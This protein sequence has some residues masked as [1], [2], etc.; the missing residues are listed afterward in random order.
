MLLNVSTI[1][2]IVEFLDFHYLLSKTQ[3]RPNSEM[4]FRLCLKIL[5][6]VIASTCVKPTPAAERTRQLLHLP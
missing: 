6:P 2:I 5:Y 1:K 4:T 3:A